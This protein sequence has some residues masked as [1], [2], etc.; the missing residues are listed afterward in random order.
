MGQ[1]MYFPPNGTFNLMYYPYYGKKEQV[2][3][4]TTLL[5]GQSIF[6]TL[7]RT[8]LYSVLRIVSLL[9]NA[10]TRSYQALHIFS[11]LSQVNYSQPLVAIKFL[12][13]TTNT[14]INVECKVTAPGIN[15]V[16]VKDKFGLKVVF[17][18]RVNSRN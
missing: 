13:L 9:E 10:V 2:Q 3:C 7:N 15:A 11:T 5:P 1:V 12:N 18:L 6:Q 14:D 4:L 17:R 16:N 8:L